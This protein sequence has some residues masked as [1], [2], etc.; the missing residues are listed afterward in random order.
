MSKVENWAQVF[1]HDIYTM[2]IGLYHPLDGVFNPKH[3]LLHFLTTNFLQ[4]EEGRLLAG[5]GSA[6]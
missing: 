1:V 5:I 4:R 6:I 3:K 2:A